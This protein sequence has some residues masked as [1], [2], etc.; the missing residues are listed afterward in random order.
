MKITSAALVALQTGFSAAF[1]MGFAGVT[2]QWSQVATKITSSAKM[3]TYGW[4]GNFPAMREWIGERVIK[5]LED[6]SYQVKNRDFEATVAVKKNDIEDDQLGIYGPM[7]QELGRT[8]AVNPDQLVFGQL[9]A[10]FATEC[11]DG[12]N[13]FDTDHPVGLGNDVTSVSN[14]QAGAGQAWYL[15]DVSRALKPLIYQERQAAN[16]VAQTDPSDEGVFKRKEFVYGV[17][18]RENAGF[19]FWQ[20]AF[21]SKADLNAA[22]YA[23]ARAAMGSLKSDN[24]EP[25]GIMPRLLVVPPALEGAARKLVENELGANGETNEWRGTA[26]VLVCPWLA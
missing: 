22:N 14:M 7:F 3:E 6:K 16:F 5:S 8:A 15:L 17:D 9:A 1:A 13:F 25:L 23:A 11:Y 20:M 10:G 21:A 2:P 18:T 19:G 12:Q 24:G 4:L 26:E